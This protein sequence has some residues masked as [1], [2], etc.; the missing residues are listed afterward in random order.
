MEINFEF[1]DPWILKV[2]WLECFN[3]VC[4]GFGRSIK[5]GC[6]KHNS[7]EKSCTVGGTE[8]RKRLPPA[9]LE[10]GNELM[11]FLW[12][13]SCAT[14]LRIE[15]LNIGIKRWV[16]LSDLCINAIAGSRF[17]VRIAWFTFRLRTFSRIK[18]RDLRL[19]YLAFKFK[20]LRDVFRSWAR[21]LCVVCCIRSV[22]D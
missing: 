15:E 17:Y 18:S 11:G 8:N 14:R 4:Y 9:T 19:A 7:K 20:P 5:W 10:S 6:G 13:N 2:F 12:L 3:V 21:L 16:T 22:N 1:S